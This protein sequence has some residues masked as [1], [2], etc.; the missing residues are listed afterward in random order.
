MA[1]LPIEEQDS[2]S[3]EDER[4]RSYVKIQCMYYDNYYILIDTGKCNGPLLLQ[5]WCVLFNGWKAG[6]LEKV[7]AI[8]WKTTSVLIRRGYI[9]S[10]LTYVVD[11]LTWPR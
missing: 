2:Y 1:M 11:N 4:F 3:I 8:G 5:K 6:D 7:P 9:W 10:R